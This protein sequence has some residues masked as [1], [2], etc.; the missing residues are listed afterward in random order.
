MRRPIMIKFQFRSACLIPVGRTWILLFAC[1]LFI[2][3]K[4]QSFSSER[5][6][7]MRF[8]DVHE[9]SVV[10]VYGE[11]IWMVP[12]D[13]GVATRLTIHDGQERFPKFSPNGK[14]IAFTGEYDGNGDVYV[15]NA[16]GGEITR[17][18][19]HPGYDEVV[20][21]HPLKNKIIFRSARHSFSRF[22]R[23]FLIAPDGTGL[24]E[25]ILCEAAGGSFSP[26]GK[27]IAYNKV[28]RENRTWK[29]YQG[30]LAQEVYLYDMETNQEKNLTHFDGTDRIPMWI[31]DKIYFSSDRDHVLN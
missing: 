5:N 17:V 20:G 24:E 11:D 7:L 15:M 9:N 22:L 12:A 8:P 1:L 4:I 21:W 29:R 27:K 30:G 23:L 3:P 19:Y 2:C 28:S 26:D 6:P 18:T 10:F 25:L 16:H 31:A 13:G 14:R